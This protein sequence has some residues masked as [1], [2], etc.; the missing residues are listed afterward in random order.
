MSATVYKLA[1]CNDCSTASCSLRSKLYRTSESPH[2]FDPHAACGA[3]TPETDINSM[4]QLEQARRDTHPISRNPVV[5]SSVQVETEEPSEIPPLFLQVGGLTHPRLV[6]DARFFP[7]LDRLPRFLADTSE[8]NL[9]IQP[10]SWKPPVLHYG[11]RPDIEML[12]AHAQKRGLTVTLKDKPRVYGENILRPSTTYWPREG[13]DEITVPVTISNPGTEVTHQEVV[14][15]IETVVHLLWTPTDDNYEYPPSTI[16]VYSTICAALRDMLHD[17]VIND[18]CGAWC[19]I[20]VRIAL[21]L[22][23]EEGKHNYLISIMTSELEDVAEGAGRA[24]NL[25]PTLEDVV[26]LGRALGITKPPQWFIDRDDCVWT[27]HFNRGRRGQ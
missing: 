20:R 19:R 14:T 1:F 15:G 23:E 24:D 26:Q 13:G 10:G 17:F 8:W 16:D 11:W 2:I 4:E 3:D 27:D 9:P 21:T 5:Q 22:Q 18:I 25:P 7:P 12:L 6:W